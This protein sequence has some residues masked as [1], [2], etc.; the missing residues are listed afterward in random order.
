M[1]IT[2]ERNTLSFLTMRVLNEFIWISLRNPA[3]CLQYGWDDIK[4]FLFGSRLNS[5]RF[6]ETDG[7]YM[8][9]GTKVK[10]SSPDAACHA[11]TVWRQ[12]F[13]VGTIGLDISFLVWYM[14]SIG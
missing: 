11:A 8:D 6:P 4:A 14:A 3:F 12:G 1:N 5:S 13:A 9:P 2:V 7:R 10:I